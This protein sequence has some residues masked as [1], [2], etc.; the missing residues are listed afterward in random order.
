[1]ALCLTRVGKVDQG[2]L[3][4]PIE[5]MDRAWLEVVHGHR[6]TVPQAR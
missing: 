1:M 6:V 5:F 3:V 4:D 2:C